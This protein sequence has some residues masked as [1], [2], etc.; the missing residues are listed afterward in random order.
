MD[1]QDREIWDEIDKSG[2][3]FTRK[4]GNKIISLSAEENKRWAEAVKPIL[5]DYVNNMKE[6]RPSRRGSPKVLSG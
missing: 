1:R 2:K 6:Q 3:E 5:Q 4:L